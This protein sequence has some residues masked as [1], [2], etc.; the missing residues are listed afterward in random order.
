MRK[1]KI[2]VIINFL[3][4]VFLLG[5][6]GNDPGDTK[7]PSDINIP[8]DVS[9][10]SDTS[11]PSNPS[12]SSTS[13]NPSIPS[14]SR[15]SS[16]IEDSSKKDDSSSTHTHTYSREWS[17][18]DTYHWHEATCGHSTKSAYFKHSFNSWQYDSEAGINKRSC[19]TC[20]YIQKE[21]LP[22]SSH[23]HTFGNEYVYDEEYHWFPSTCGHDE[24]IEKMPHNFSD[25]SEVVDG[26]IYKSQQCLDCKYIKRGE[27][28]HT[29]SNVW[30]Y[31]NQT[32]WY[33]ATCGHDLKDAESEHAFDVWIIDSEPQSEYEIGSKHRSCI[34]CNYTEYETVHYVHTPNYDMNKWYYNENYHYHV[35]EDHPINENEYTEMIPH[36]GNWVLELAPTNYRPGYIYQT[37]DVCGYVKSK[38]IPILNSTDYTIVHVDS[39]VDCQHSSHGFYAYSYENFYETFEGTV[40]GKHNYVDNVCSVC[41]HTEVSEGLEYRLDN[42]GKYYYVCGIGEF[43]DTKL[44]IPATYNNLPVVGIDDEVFKDC[45][46]LTYISL[47]KS[48]TILGENVFS[49]CYNVTE[50]STHISPTA[51][52]GTVKY[53]NSL[54][55]NQNNTKYYIPEGLTKISIEFLTNSNA[56]TFKNFTNVLEINILNTE[57]FAIPTEA[58]SNTTSLEKLTM[59]YALVKE[60]K[61]NAFYN[62]NYPIDLSLFTS[63][64]YIRSNAFLK[65]E[66]LS[67]SL[68]IPNSVITIEENAFPGE[69]VKDVT[70]ISL[71]FIGNSSKPTYRDAGYFYFIFGGRNYIPKNLNTLVITGNTYLYN[72]ALTGLQ[73][74]E[75]FYVSTNYIECERGDEFNYLNDNV[76]N[77]YNNGKYLGDNENPYRIFIMPINFDIEEITLHNDVKSLIN[78]AFDGSAIT[79]LIIP[80]N[81]EYFPNLTNSNL[82]SLTIPFTPNDNLRTYIPTTLKTLNIT[83]GTIANNCLNNC[84]YLENIYIADDVKIESYSRLFNDCSSLVEI[85]LPITVDMALLFMFSEHKSS[86]Y[87]YNKMYYYNSE[88]GYDYTYYIPSTLTKITITNNPD[89]FTNFFSTSYSSDH[90]PFADITIDNL[91]TATK[92]LFTSINTIKK[93]TINNEL[94]VVGDN[95]F[96]NFQQLEEFNAPDT[97]STI[98]KYAFANCTLL[99]P[100][101]LSTITK[102][103]NYAFQNNKFT[104]VTLSENIEYIGD[105]PFENNLNINLNL[106]KTDN[107]IYIGSN[108]FNGATM[109]EILT[110]N[111]SKLVIKSQAFKD[112]L[113]I[114]EI[115]ILNAKVIEDNI[116]AGLTLSKITLPFVNKSTDTSYTLGYYFQT[117]QRDNT[118]AITIPNTTNIYFIPNTLTNITILSGEMVSYALANLTSVITINLTTNS[119]ASGLFYNCNNLE[120][121]TINGTYTSIPAN[122]FEGTKLKAIEIPNTV[123][124]IGEQAFKNTLITS[125]VIPNSVNEI[126][127][128]IFEG[129]NIESLTMPDLNNH[130]LGY[131]FN[132]ENINLKSLK[133]LTITSATTLVDEALA[134][135]T[136]LENLTILSASSYGARVIYNTT[137]LTTLTVDAST[138]EYFGSLF[139][140]E[141]NTIT[142]NP[143]NITNVKLLKAN[144]I[145]SNYLNGYTIPNLYLP[146]S[147]LKFEANSLFGFK[148]TSIY[149]DGQINEWSKIEH[150][151]QSKGT[152]SGYALYFKNDNDYYLANEIT[153]NQNSIKTNEFYYVNSINKLIIDNDV[154]SINV[155]MNLYNNSFDLYYNDTLVNWCNITFKYEYYN[156]ISQAN[157][158][159]YL[160]NNNYSLAE[161]I[162]I[163]ANASSL[164]NPSFV[165]YKN[166]K[167]LTLTVEPTEL[168]LNFATFDNNLDALNKIDDGYYYGTIDNPKLFLYMYDTKATGDVVISNNT[169]YIRD[170]AFLNIASITSIT[171]P[172][173]IKQLGS[174]IIN[175]KNTSLEKISLP[176][177]YNSLDNIGTIPV[178]LTEINFTSGNSIP[179]LFFNG[180]MAN[181]R[182]IIP[183]NISYTNKSF[184]FIKSSIYLEEDNCKYISSVSNPYQV[185]IGV[186]SNATD[187]IINPKTKDILEDAISL[188]EINNLTISNLDFNVL[189]TYPTANKL[190]YKEIFFYGSKNLVLLDGKQNDGV[191]ITNLYLNVEEINTKMPLQKI[192]N[193]YLKQNVNVTNA[194][195]SDSTITNIYYDGSISNWLNIHYNNKNEIIASNSNLFY[196][197][198]DSYTLLEELTI[199]KEITYLYSYQFAKIT[200]IKKVLIPTTIEFIEPYVF[201]DCSNIN[202]FESPQLR[203]YTPT[204]FKEAVYFFTDQVNNSNKINIEN[205]SIIGS[206][207]FSKNSLK[208]LV[209]NNLYIAS[210]LRY[211]AFEDFTIMYLARINNVYFNGIVTDWLKYHFT[212]LSDHPASTS[213]AK[214]YF[215][216]SDSNYIQ[217][218]VLDLSDYTSPIFN[219][220]F[221]GINT[222]TKL[223]LSSSVAINSFDN[224]IITEIELVN[225]DYNTNFA[226]LLSQVRTLTLNNSLI[227]EELPYFDNLDSLYLYNYSSKLGNTDKPFK[228]YQGKHLNV[229]YH[230]TPSDW[231]N[232][233]I[234]QNEY[235]NPMIAGSFSF[236][237]DGKYQSISTLNIEATDKL[238]Q[239]HFSNLRSLDTVIIDK[240][241]DLSKASKA[242]IN[243]NVKNIT[244][245]FDKANLFNLFTNELDGVVPDFTSVTIVGENVNRSISS[246]VTNL[247]LD[248]S[249]KNITTSFINASF[250]KFYYNGTL[251]D[252]CNITFSYDDS[253]PLICANSIYF[254]N[255]E[256]NKIEVP[257]SVTTIGN[258]QFLGF[259]ATEVIVPNTVTS[260]GKAFDG[261]KVN[262]LTVPFIT[263]GKIATMFSNN[264]QS[265][266]E[267]HVTNDTIIADRGFANLEYLQSAIFDGNITSMGDEA[268]YRCSRMATLTISSTNNIGKF[269]FAACNN[270]Q[271]LTIPYIQT[272]SNSELNYFKVLFLDRYAANTSP[273][274]SSAIKNAKSI[275]T[276]VELTINEGK[277]PANY[278]ID[279]SL[280]K[281]IELGNVELQ[282]KSFYGLQKLYNLNNI[283]ADLKFTDLF[284]I[285][286]STILKYVQLKIKEGTTSICEDFIRDTPVGGVNIPNTV[287]SIGKNAF[288]NN[289]SPYLNIV[290]NGTINEW[291]SISFA[292]L[293]ANPLV[294]NNAH[295][296]YFNSKGLLS[297]DEGIVEIDLE[298][299]KPFAIVGLNFNKMIFSDKLKYIGNDNFINCNFLEYNNPDEIA[300]DK[301]L[302]N[303]SNP[304]MI[305]IYHQGSIIDDS[306]TVNSNTKIIYDDAFKNYKYLATLNV[307]SNIIQIGKQ[308]IEYNQEC[309]ERNLYYAGSFDNWLDVKFDSISYLKNIYFEGALITDVEIPDNKTELNFT[310]FKY[311]N[312]ESL[313]IPTSVTKFSGDISN[314]T[315]NN[316]YYNGSLSDWLN[317]IIEASP[318]SITN[319]FY[320]DN[321]VISGEVTIP[322]STTK[323]NDN[324]F[325]Y[326]KNVTSYIIPSGITYIGDYAF[327]N[328]TKLTSIIIP[329]GVTY[330]GNYAFANNTALTSISIPSTIKDTGYSIFSK[331]NNLTYYE[332]ENARYLGNSENNYVI[333][334]ERIEFAETVIIHPNTKVIGYQSMASYN[335]NYNNL[336]IPDGVE[337]IG[338]VAFF[339]TQSDYTLIVP[340]TIKYIGEDGL[341][342]ASSSKIF[343]KGTKEEFETIEKVN[344]TTKATIY[345]YSEEKP[346][347]T[348]NY[349]HYVNENPTSY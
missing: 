268:F 2:L 275:S 129:D 35:C 93:L 118:Y 110:F 323:I 145:Y 142:Y 291:L 41:G 80:N 81:I 343:Y 177:M 332:Y 96:E 128:G 105:N 226:S 87:N 85:K 341:Y 25:Y 221:T 124:S 249:V 139:G 72:D 58:F 206:T 101:N 270:I 347:E 24:A 329:N 190:E 266:H 62:C 5:A 18:N 8:S 43:N 163:P 330:I 296:S 90:Y 28:I 288:L 175:E 262:K 263:N 191:Y 153:I 258:Y 255:E 6:C 223:K 250:T 276:L 209:I 239:Y 331:C 42:L 192:E 333:L 194:D 279:T 326:F 65:Y 9:I 78:N 335:G 344:F 157:S 324:Q 211:D 66:H 13:N 243:T 334:M 144:T 300:G 339:R 185:L 60:I 165:G 301:Y 7:L 224:N 315:I 236:Y 164:P 121:I 261:T 158:F 328:N 83:G 207:P 156:P 103:D 88:T 15:T 31:D 229:Y 46:N 166:I 325:R 232:N 218:T 44:M 135:L 106:T 147:L 84:N 213:D 168:N 76:F 264:A 349:W 292:N 14:D 188:K 178:S 23:T 215:K 29:Y 283:S 57:E 198:N 67:S 3:V 132:D 11:I 217:P 140:N 253:N 337:S 305:L 245:P 219:Y 170:N 161:N 127:S 171:I 33:Q 182:V 55:I 251:E 293:N 30:S 280:I 109:N 247:I 267:I 327:A 113:G 287:K 45:T 244:M 97:L 346:S 49:G 114:N 312:L 222:I 107:L 146:S 316:I 63:L 314:L 257:S 238:S 336:V 100:F 75:A 12:T 123:T 181:V 294:T 193:L 111:N 82:I 290:F 131:L 102:I 95:A 204:G 203:A 1:N 77:I 174:I 19:K 117:E 242:F 248:I 269:A 38:E 130:N 86:G 151:V 225:I 40:Y 179:E 116:F 307:H 277:I 216:D 73:N 254:N 234:F 201:L 125:I 183:D 126:A 61:A 289:N 149:Y 231:M 148:G 104:N 169:S 162:V 89:N 68:I 120:N 309:E 320:I 233:T 133:N 345:Y 274:L 92:D 281:T 180:F 284:D 134:N 98:G 241:C 342:L 59:N 298:E 184:S 285:T 302:G 317:I 10:P 74:L 47:P 186:N 260:I 271:Y 348:G 143:A 205:M 52:F 94:R 265:L 4:I 259:K 119:L 272:Y 54:E 115:H 173:T 196:K 39:P 21:N 71:P 340:K 230:G 304:Y 16:I 159:Y 27:H 37:C 79:N 212:N 246:T 208:N 141:I 220:A 22:I 112:A 17:Y 32:H 108:A 338:Y 167:S 189:P 51:M 69:S 282:E 20:G 176:L 313:T 278:F 227:R 214:L 91:T 228:N 252:W 155:N 136:S 195:F 53:D 311:L 295:F 210:T 319:N 122:V 308:D 299:I 150:N 26:I 199:P 137:S 321:T 322:S 48:I 306:F 297:Q 256:I 70:Y 237:I 34:I 286:D 273:D 56:I 197:N 50:I 235:Q 310:K 172:D 36:M 202:Y 99:N 64:Q 303:D 200:S 160:D 187:I 318:V 154:T 240:D 138:L 152:T